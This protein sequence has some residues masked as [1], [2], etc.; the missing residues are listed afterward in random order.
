MAKRFFFLHKIVILSLILFV[1]AC[2]HKHVVNNEFGLLNHDENFVYSNKG[3]KLYYQQFGVGKPIIIVHG[4]QGLDHQYLM[5][6]MLELAKDHKVIV[7]DQRGCGNS[8]YGKINHKNISIKQSVED[9]EQIRQA[10]DLGEVILLGHSFGGLLATNYAIKYPNNVKALILANSASITSKG[11][12]AFEEE[13]KK[14]VYNPNKKRLDEITSSQDFIDANPKAVARFHR[15][16]FN[17]YFANSKKLS[18]MSLN[19]SEE[20]TISGRKVFEI[21]AKHDLARHYDLRKNLSHLTVPTLI[22]HGNKDIIPVWTA[23]E[24]HASIPNSKLI[25]LKNCGH[26]SYIEC[27]SEFFSAIRKFL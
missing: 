26:F 21:F 3:G 24:I 22:I 14:V 5:P 23:E 13:Y 9:L 8:I 20:A 10:L 11:L 7:Y 25:V 18:S 16:V 1:S 19:L 27:P 4:G 2:N 15:I 17:K 6:Q 12:K